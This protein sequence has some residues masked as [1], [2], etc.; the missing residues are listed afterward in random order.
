MERPNREPCSI[1]RVTGNETG[2]AAAIMQEA[3]RWLHDRGQPPWNP[4]DLAPEALAP[5]VARGEVYLARRGDEAVG[6]FLM[7]PDDPAFWPDVPAGESFFIHKLAIR[8]QVA[9]QGVGHAMLR[10]AEGATARAG[11]QYLRLDCDDRPPLRAYYEA[12]GFTRHDISQ[13]GPYRI[14]RY[15]RIVRDRGDDVNA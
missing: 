2:I 6:A 10:W 1:T 8:R 7:L 13:V 12:A 11:R 5:L 9:G 3:A 4:E 15:E 14:V